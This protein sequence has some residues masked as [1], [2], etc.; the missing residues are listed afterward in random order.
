MTALFYMLNPLWE[1][2]IAPGLLIAV[3]WWLHALQP[4][5]EP[6]RPYD[7]AQEDVEPGGLFPPT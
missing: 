2:L 5:P 3:G 1:F 6:R 4:S 7:W